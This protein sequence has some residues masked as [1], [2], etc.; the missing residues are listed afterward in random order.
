MTAALMAKAALKVAVKDTVELTIQGGL[1]YPRTARQPPE[2]RRWSK[3]RETG[4][5]ATFIK[6]SI[7]TLFSRYLCSLTRL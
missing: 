2:K 1:G 5:P 4:A 7:L 6:R 3:K